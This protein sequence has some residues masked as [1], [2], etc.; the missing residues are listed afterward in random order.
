M[1]TYQ[2][3]KFWWYSRASHAQRSPE[4]V[5]FAFVELAGNDVDADGV[6][7]QTHQDK[8]NGPL[9]GQGTQF[10]KHM[11]SSSRENETVDCMAM[12]RDHL[13]AFAYGFGVEFGT[14]PEAGGVDTGSASSPVR[15]RVS[16][17][18]R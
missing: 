18:N 8:D 6:I 11:D 17:R 16:A 10:F 4:R 14:G 9:P 5:V 3:G 7:L 13:S 12:V 15:M 1:A 2:R